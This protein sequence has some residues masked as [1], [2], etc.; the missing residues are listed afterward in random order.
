METRVRKQVCASQELPTIKSLLQELQ[1]A[2]TQLDQERAQCEALKQEHRVELEALV[3]ERTQELQAANLNLRM[4]M[5]ERRAAARGSPSIGN[6]NTL[7][8][9]RRGNVLT[10]C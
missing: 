3:V 5:A 8:G 1:R 6:N 9:I 10:A 2:N 4:Q 7:T